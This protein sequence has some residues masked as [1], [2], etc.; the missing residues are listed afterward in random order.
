VTGARSGPGAASA[1]RPRRIDHLV[2]NARFAVDAAR[3]AWARLGFTLTPRGFHT[4]GSINHLIVLQ[5]DYV[6]LL[7]LP[8]GQDPPSR[9]ELATGAPGLFACAF[10][11]TDADDDRRE[12][13]ARGWPADPVQQFSRPVA[14]DPAGGVRDAVFRTVRFARPVTAGGRSFLCQ[15]LT[16]ELVWRGEWQAHE[17]GALRLAGFAI[18]ADDPESVAAEWARLA[19]APTE[20]RT[21]GR[22]AV[23]LDGSVLEVVPVAS[24]I[25]AGAGGATRPGSCT[26]WMA[27]ISLAVE[28][29]ERCAA[30]LARRGVPAGRSRRG[31][32]VPPAAAA[33]TAVEFVE[34]TRAGAP[35]AR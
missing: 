6:E 24:A 23:L 32:V 20:P 35:E 4:L 19:G 16:P 34:E 9:P 25:A 18:A 31:I 22:V 8:P 3:D 5:D 2:V 13:V 14:A 11:S 29:L 28:S 12:L 7:G 27:G 1:A 10:G 26:A 15:H 21:G 33:G 17:N 30:L